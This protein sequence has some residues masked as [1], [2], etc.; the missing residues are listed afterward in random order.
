MPLKTTL[1]PADV[2]AM[3]PFGSRVITLLACLSL[4]SCGKAGAP[5]PTASSRTTTLAQFDA[6]ANGIC[7]T[8]TREQ[9]AIEQRSRIPGETG[10]AVWHELVAASR[11]ADNE[12]RASPKPLAQASVIDQL[13]VAYFR[14]A[15]DEEEIASA[16]GA[17][18]ADR[19]QTAFATFLRLA[20]RD[21]AVARRLGMTACAKAEPEE[22]FPGRGGT[23]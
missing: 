4:M 16:Y 13:V 21:A 11:S 9:E 8:L 10:E 1:R 18:E 23:A 3:R 15:Q 20:R 6:R 19:I 7:M 12:V 14:E 5:A 2:D 17:N 22:R